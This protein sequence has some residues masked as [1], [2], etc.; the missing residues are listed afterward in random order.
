MPCFTPLMVTFA[1]KN[2]F[3]ILRF[4]LDL[5]DGVGSRELFDRGLDGG[6]N[7]REG[8]RLFG[9][10]LLFGGH[11]DGEPRDKGESGNS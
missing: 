3:A 1:S 7:I 9:L 2:G 8:Q 10:L 5:S 11:I 6:W 4:L